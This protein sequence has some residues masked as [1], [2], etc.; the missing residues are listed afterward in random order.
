VPMH[1]QHGETLSAGVY[2]VHALQMRLGSLVNYR[3]SLAPF[4]PRG[5]D[6]PQRRG[7]KI[8]IMTWV[9]HLSTLYATARYIVKGRLCRDG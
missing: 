3:S 9:P 2:L 1:Q 7:H 5:L 8:A 6:H 4:E